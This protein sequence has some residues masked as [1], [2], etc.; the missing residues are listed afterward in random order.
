MPCVTYD[1]R[2][3]QREINE[4]HLIKGALCMMLS[5]HGLPPANSNWY[6]AAGI[7]R[8]ELEEW[9]NRHQTEDSRRKNQER[10]EKQKQELRKQAMAK[11][12]AAEK[13]ALGV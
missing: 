1:Y 5:N 13:K 12:T 8:A 9:W 11:L 3:E 4:Q 6:K 7:E 2:E 10:I